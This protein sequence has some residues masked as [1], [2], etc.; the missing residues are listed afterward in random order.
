[1][2]SE[3]KNQIGNALFFMKKKT[4]FKFNFT[5]LKAV[6]IVS[7]IKI[8]FSLKRESVCLK[9]EKY[10]TILNGQQKWNKGQTRNR[11]I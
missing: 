4:S 10:I 8:K 3:K 1:M 6:Y 7:F 2:Q 11:C 9:Y 5:G